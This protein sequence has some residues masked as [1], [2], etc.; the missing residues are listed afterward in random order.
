[1]IDITLWIPAIV[2]SAAMLLALYALRI[3]QRHKRR[4]DVQRVIWASRLASRDAQ[5]A[6][7]KR[8]LDDKRRT[9]PAPSFS[10][11]ALED[12]ARGVE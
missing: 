6:Q 12:R 7:L 8:A 5:I 10:A 11:R 4:F 9:D 1:M 2:S 3:A